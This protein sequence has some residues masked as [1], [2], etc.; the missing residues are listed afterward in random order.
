MSCVISVE[1]R[2]L[3]G[4]SIH[5]YRHAMSTTE[6]EP[7][8]GLTRFEDEGTASVETLLADIETWPDSEVESLS[9]AGDGTGL[10]G[11]PAADLRASIREVLEGKGISFAIGTNAKG[12]V[13][14]VRRTVTGALAQ[15]AIDRWAGLNGFNGG[16][17]CKLGSPA[18]P[19]TVVQR[20]GTLLR[21][22]GE[23]LEHWERES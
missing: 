18:K 23:K 1:T 12:L 15:R 17:E 6:H 21:T 5:I 3:D 13:L 11:A 7:T 14:E 9:R 20:I 22:F 2:K 10:R 19:R 8:T 16:T 4:V